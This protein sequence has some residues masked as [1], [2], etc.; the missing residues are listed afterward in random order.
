MKQV[1]FYNV[2]KSA[3][4]K[5]YKDPKTKIYY[6]FTTTSSA[7]FRTARA[8]AQKAARMIKTWGESSS[9]PFRIAEF[10]IGEGDFAVAFNKELLKH[11][12]HTEFEYVMFDFSKPLLDK[13]KKQFTKERLIGHF[14]CCDL[15]NPAK[16][17]YARSGAF[18]YVISNEMYDDL[19]ASIACRKG[20]EILEAAYDRD[21]NFTGYIPCANKKVLAFAQNLPE[22]YNIP[23]NLG[24][25]ENL[26]LIKSILRPRTG[27]ADIFDYGFMSYKEIEKEP[28]DFW[29]QGIVRKFGEQLTTDVN[30][31][32][33]EEYAKSIGFIAGSMQQS[34]FI[35]MIIGEKL[36]SVELEDGW[37]YFTRAEIKKHAKKL[38]KQG[39][40]KE[41]IKGDFSEDE[42]YYC[43]SLKVLD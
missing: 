35:E 15:A 13:A 43:L 37:H 19:P 11:A 22:N 40:G 34:D 31:E 3:N 20:K 9:E 33:L 42:P 17:P 8:C 14:V 38:E 6:D 21:G 41:F 12:D 28:Y 39:Y 32:L 4:E 16:F 24:A 5:Y 26:E 18:D 27:M 1:T 36:T 7:C 10:G 25:M 30:F 29:N 2:Q 23:V